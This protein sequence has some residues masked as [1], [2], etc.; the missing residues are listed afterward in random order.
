LERKVLKVKVQDKVLN[1]F[2]D[3]FKDYFEPKVLKEIKIKLNKEIFPQKG[4][5]RQREIFDRLYFS[6]KI[7]ILF[8]YVI[9]LGQKYL[10]TAKIVDMLF[11]LSKTAISQGEFT[12]ANDLCTHLLSLTKGEPQYKNIRS[13]ALLLIGEIN[14]RQA[15]WAQSFDYL[16]KAKAEFIR[17]ND[18]IGLAN[19]ENLLGTIYGEL[20]EVKKAEKY[21]QSAFYYLDEKRDKVTIAGI[22]TNLGIINNISGKLDIAFSFFKRS[23]LRFELLGD[24]RRV[25]ELRHNLGMNYTKKQNFNKAINEF[26]RSINLSL[27]YRYLPTLAISLLSKSYICVEQNEYDLATAYAN[28]G[29]EISHRINDKLSI[30]D[31]YKINGIIRRKQKNYFEAENYFLS[32]LRINKDLN[33]KLNFA[34]TSFE[35]GLLYKD[36]N[37]SKE[38]NVHFNNAKTYYKSI[39]ADEEVVRINS[40]L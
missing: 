29:M 11:T 26:D 8:D 5:K 21:F 40:Y 22:E 34:E 13:N 32:S 19:C 25:A 17:Q 7:R 39:G 2:Q 3:I 20:G 36:M 28:K 37:N 15:Y 23:L 18:L 6:E 12:I 4:S 1:Q 33:N 38:A 10:D 14:S 31:I 9:S 27:K 24:F 30:A 16:K 35:L